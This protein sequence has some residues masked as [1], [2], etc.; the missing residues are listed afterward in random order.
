MGALIEWI[1]N[2]I[3]FVVVIIGILSS[4]LGNGK[5]HK[6]G[7]MPTFGGD[8]PGRP[9]RPLDRRKTAGREIRRHAGQ[10]T[11]DLSSRRYAD[12]RADSLPQPSSPAVSGTSRPKQ[13]DGGTSSPV[14]QTVYRSRF[15]T[16][17]GADAG[18]HRYDRTMPEYHAGEP[19]SSSRYEDERPAA[20]AAEFPAGASPAA[21]SPVM[22]SPFDVPSGQAGNELS[23][24]GVSLSELGEEM[25]SDRTSPVYQALYSGNLQHKALEGIIWAELLGPPR[26]LRKNRGRRR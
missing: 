19:A 4:I 26:A 12:D 15:D 25:I 10:E 17:A 13:A 24:S 21:S 3:V 7:G 9:D 16:P 11:G 6:G 18:R 20:R 5:Q 8:L 1:L 2:N 14:K 22:N 23:R